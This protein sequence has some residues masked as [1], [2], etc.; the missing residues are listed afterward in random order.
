MFWRAG[1]TFKAVGCEVCIESNDMFIGASKRLHALIY[2]S[3][4]PNMGRQPPEQFLTTN[5]PKAPD[6]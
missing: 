4:H 6:G 5:P 1:F 3:T 2:A